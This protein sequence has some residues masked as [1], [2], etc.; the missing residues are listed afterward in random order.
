MRTPNSLLGVSYIVTSG[1]FGSGF[2]VGNCASFDASFPATCPFVIA[3]GETELIV[4]AVTEA[5]WV[6]SDGGFSNIF[7]RAK[8]Q[9]AAV[10]AYFRT[11]G[12]NT[13]SLFNVSGCAVPDVSVICQAPFYFDRTLFEFASTTA[14]SASIF[15]SMAALLTNERIAV[16]MSGLEFLNPLIYQNP[17]AFNEIAT[18]FNHGCQ[19]LGFSG[20]IG[21]DR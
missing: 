21:W 11:V 20:K 14:I 1:D 12:A 5:A 10:E 2:P 17:G 13:S 7:Q 3:V 9:D 4:D 16:G 15:A 6:S 8:Y 18:G 19:E